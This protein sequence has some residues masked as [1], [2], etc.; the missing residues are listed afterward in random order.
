MRFRRTSVQEMQDFTAKDTKGAKKNC[1]R[2]FAQMNADQNKQPKYA[3]HSNFSSR[4]F[5]AEDAESA[6][7]NLTT[8]CTDSTD[9]HGLGQ[10]QASR[11]TNRKTQGLRYQKSLVVIGFLRFA[12]KRRQA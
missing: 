9:L 6:E 12:R 5:T 7:K 1:C 11:I 4:I 10:R 2:R 3:N 8:D